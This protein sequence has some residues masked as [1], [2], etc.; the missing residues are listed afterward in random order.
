[1]T[2]SYRSR[3]NPN[4]LKRNCREVIGALAKLRPLWGYHS[5]NKAYASQAEMM[6][7]VT[8]T[9]YLESFADRA[10]KC[11]LQYAAATGRGCAMPVYRRNMFGQGH[12]ELKLYTYGSPCVLPVQ[13]P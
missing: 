13:L 12:G 9:W 3:A 4:R 10:I 2:A 8:R 7:K 11:A 5:D 1:T 6:N